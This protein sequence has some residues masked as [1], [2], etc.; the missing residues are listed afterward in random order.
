MT[1]GEYLLTQRD[2]QMTMA[3]AKQKVRDFSSA[4]M[5]KNIALGFQI[6]LEKSTVKELQARHE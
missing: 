1:K 4:R 5:H 2:R 6:K 3:I